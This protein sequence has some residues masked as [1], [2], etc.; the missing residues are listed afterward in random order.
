[1]RAPG[2]RRPHIEVA[3]RGEIPKRRAAEHPPSTSPAKED[4]DQTATND[5]ANFGRSQRT[6][7]AHERYFTF[8]SPWG[9]A[10]PLTRAHSR[11]LG[12]CFKTGRVR[13]RMETPRGAPGR[14]FGDDLT[15][16]GLYEQG[17]RTSPRRTGAHLPIFN[18]P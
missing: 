7:S 11:L 9:L 3:N 12:P 18:R 15:L 4:I 1:M 17:Q 5:P 16:L 6:G 8:V 2:L 10:S 14:L 13:N